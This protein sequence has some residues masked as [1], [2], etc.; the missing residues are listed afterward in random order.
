MSILAVAL[1]LHSLEYIAVCGQAFTS[2]VGEKPN[3]DM[4]NALSH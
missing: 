1:V 4:R 2:R 3:P